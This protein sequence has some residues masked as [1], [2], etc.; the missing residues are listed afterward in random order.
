MLVIIVGRFVVL[1]V[2][3]FQWLWGFP[4]LAYADLKA[5][6]EALTKQEREVILKGVDSLC[7]DTWCEGSF[8]FEFHTFLCRFEVNKCWLGFRYIDIYD[9][10]NGEISYRYHSYKYKRKSVGLESLCVI[11]VSTRR[12]LF[13]DNEGVSSYL[14][15]QVN[16]C[17][18]E[19]SPLAEA[20]LP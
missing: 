2:L 17:I 8:E 10:K 4:S 18:D 5:G 15:D 20:L 1:L 14:Y 7:G 13:G 16:N 9:Y 12:D 3:L 6:E 19:S 11:E